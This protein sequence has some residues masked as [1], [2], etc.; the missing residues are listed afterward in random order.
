MSRPSPTRLLRRIRAILNH[1]TEAGSDTPRWTVETLV[2]HNRARLVEAA[3]LLAVSGYSRL[4][5]EALAERLLPALHALAE[6]AG[7]GVGTSRTGGAAAT[8]EPPPARGE[9]DVARGPVVEVSEEEITATKFDLG[10]EVEEPREAHIPWGYG[11]NRITAMAIDPDR[12]YCY[13]EVTDDAIE[14][15]RGRLGPGGPTAWLNLRV[16][17]VTGRIFDGTNA[18]AYFDIR[19]ERTDRQWFITLNKPTSTQV[20]EVG[21]KSYEGYFVKIARSHRVDMPRKAPAPP[22]PVE[23]LTVRPESGEVEGAAAPGSHDGGGAGAEREPGGATP[24]EGGHPAPGHDDASPVAASLA[25]AASVQHTSVAS[26][27][28]LSRAERFEWAGPV[29]RTSWRAGPF[30]LQ[31]EAPGRVEERYQG[32]T[33]VVTEAGGGRLVCG[34]WEV[35]IRG[36]GGWAEGRVVAHWRVYKSWP[37]EEGHEVWAV[38]APLA[39]TAAAPGGEAASPGGASERWWGAGSEQWLGGASELYRLGASE[40]RLGGASEQRWAGASEVRFA[41]GS[42]E[43]WGGASELSYLG[44]SERIHLGGSEARLGHGGAGEHLGGSEARLASGSG[45]GRWPA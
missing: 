41:G 32:P 34:P 15:A 9:G 19:V 3:K 26:H 29:R 39:V 31:V 30:P 40:L 44:G 17:D 14:E 42:E 4:R 38:A 36:L 8:D 20:V 27:T 37:V 5:K 13:W 16:Y 10:P 33:T 35:V 11:D 45:E 2:R 28:W 23:W 12:L 18:H 43:V 25:P 22:A 1:A 7:V 21:L 6:R 24:G